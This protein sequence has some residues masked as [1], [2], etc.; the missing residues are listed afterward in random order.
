MKIPSKPKYPRGIR[1]YPTGWRVCVRVHA[2][3]GGLKS[4]VFPAAT[5]L[6]VM[7][8]WR[9]EQR[10]RARLGAAVLPPRGRT[11]REDIADYLR[12]RQTMPTLRHRRDDL[13]RWL[14]VFAA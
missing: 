5:S 6:T 2:G 14:T 13:R 4:R 9:E 7:R 3:P 8:Q 12:Q 1:P 11:L 10:V